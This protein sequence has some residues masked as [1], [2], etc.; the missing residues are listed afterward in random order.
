MTLATKSNN[1]NLFQSLSKQA[2][3]MLILGKHD[4]ARP[5][6]RKWYV[7]VGIDVASYSAEGIIIVMEH[8]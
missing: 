7:N 5:L 8:D 3:V 6:Y 4:V 1:E 2:F